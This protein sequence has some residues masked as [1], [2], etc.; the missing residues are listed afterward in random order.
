MRK[1]VLT[2]AA[3]AALAVTAPTL[4]SAT[5]MIGGGAVKAAAETVSDVENVHYYGYRGYYR[6]YRSY[7]YYR[8]YR[9]YGYYRPYRYYGY[10]S[11]YR[12]YGYY[13]PYRYYRYW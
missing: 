13:R 10:Y 7:G 9:Y 12:Y 8:P 1:F 5:P 11:P 6:P 3:A 2:L 4:A